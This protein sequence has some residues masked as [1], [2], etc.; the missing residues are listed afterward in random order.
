MSSLKSGQL[1]G[2]LMGRRYPSHKLSSAFLNHPAIFFSTL[3]T[4][5]SKPL[6]SSSSSSYRTC[7]LALDEMT[8]ASSKPSSST[9]SRSQLHVVL[10]PK[11]PTEGLISTKEALMPGE[12]WVVP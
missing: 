4:V 11:K 1:H 10:S 7:T 3:L 8:N 5:F 6:S 12:R 2:R 9:F